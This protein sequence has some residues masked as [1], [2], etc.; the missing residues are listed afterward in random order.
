MAD[1]LRIII[2][3]ILGYRMK[4]YLN[5]QGLIY[6]EEGWSEE[7]EDKFIDE[8]IA[9]IEKFNAQTATSFRPS[10]EDEE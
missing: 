1:L 4:Q 3:N 7:D 8:Y 10:S 9:L 5:M 6:K 2:V